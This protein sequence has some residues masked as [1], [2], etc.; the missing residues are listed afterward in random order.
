MHLETVWQRNYYEY[1]L[2][3]DEYANRIYRYIQDNPRLWSED[4][5]NPSAMV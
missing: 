4:R 5:E 3:D 1:I 2:R